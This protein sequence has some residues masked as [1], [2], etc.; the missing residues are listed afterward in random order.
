LSSC[1]TDFLIIGLLY[2]WFESFPIVFSGIYG[3]SLGLEGVAFLGIF[4]GVLLAVPP[5]FWYL[6]KYVE[7]QFNDNGELKPELRLPPAF[8]GAFCI[9]ICLFWFGWSG[10]ASVHWIVP[11]IGTGWFSIGTFLLFNSVLNYLGDAY[12]EYAAS[13][14]AGND[15][16]RSSFGAG[17][18]LFASAMYNKL[19]VGR[20]SESTALGMPLTVGQAGLARHLAS[21]R[22]L[23]FLFRS[24]CIRWVSNFP[25]R[26]L[27][28]DIMVVW[29]AIAKEKQIR[30]QRFLRLS[31]LERRYPYRRYLDLARII[32][33][34]EIVNGS[35][36]NVRLR[37]IGQEDLP[38]HHNWYCN[39]RL[40]KTPS[41]FPLSSTLFS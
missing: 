41:R 5:F 28:A 21:L 3:F 7:P 18:P 24:S 40:N 25:A 6:Y 29:R 37:E 14:L 9:P 10:R 35:V 15:F 32:G 8:V 31:T 26:Y 38:F 23:S 13:V 30:A 2:I 39:K 17:F 36:V 1:V 4:V 22:S 33:F 20:Q 12:P 19:G 27:L 11:I 16:M 34:C